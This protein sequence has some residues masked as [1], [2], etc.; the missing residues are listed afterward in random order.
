MERE[1]SD[2]MQHRRLRP[3]LCEGKTGKPAKR[4]LCVCLAGA[5]IAPWLA[6][7][8][9]SR[10][11]HEAPRLS[12]SLH[13]HEE[14]TRVRRRPLQGILEGESSLHGLV[15]LSLSCSRSFFLSFSRGGWTEGGAETKPLHELQCTQ[16]AAALSLVRNDG[17]PKYG[18]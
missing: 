13:C 10:R 11:R 9:L 18:K 15:S 6:E 4:P 7:V 16:A 2:I 3:R 17:S 14:R 8:F 12:T 5:R 1:A